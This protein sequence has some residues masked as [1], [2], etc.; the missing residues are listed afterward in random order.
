MADGV[1]MKFLTNIYDRNV[2][3]T[4]YETQNNKDKNQYGT[5]KSVFTS[6]FY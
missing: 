5:I 2:K 4:K 1:T 6:R 3:T